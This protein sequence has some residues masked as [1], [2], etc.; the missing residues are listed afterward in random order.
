LEPR[1]FAASVEKHT[2]A[3]TWPPNTDSSQ[4]A[5]V[6]GE[7]SNTASGPTTTVGGGEVWRSAKGLEWVPALG[8]ELGN[9][10]N[11]RPYGL[12]VAGDELYLTF[13]NQAP[14]PAGSCPAGGHGPRRDTGGV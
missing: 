11:L 10:D 6:G 3:K 12:F 8:Q 14:V 5:T 13:T 4:Y 2:I 9:P 1:L 7:L